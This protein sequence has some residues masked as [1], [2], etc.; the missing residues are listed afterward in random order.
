[1]AALITAETWL[2]AAGWARGNHTC[3]GTMP[4]LVANPAASSTNATDAEVDPG[5]R[6]PIRSKPTPPAST[7]RTANPR[8]R[9]TKLSWVSAAYHSAACLTSAR[10]R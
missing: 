6:A 2:G 4:A 3:T 1:M 9:S 10:S 5:S 7:A 8:S